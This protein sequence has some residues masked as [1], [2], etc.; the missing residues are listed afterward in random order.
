M[1]NNDVRGRQRLRRVPPG[2]ESEVWAVSGSQEARRLSPRPAAPLRPASKYTIS[3]S[4]LARRP[5]FCSQPLT[6][7]QSGREGRRRGRFVKPHL[8]P[9]APV[10]DSSARQ[11]RGRVS[12]VR[13]KA[14]NAH[15]ERNEAA[16]WWSRYHGDLD[17]LWGS[18]SRP[19]GSLKVVCRKSF[20]LARRRS[21]SSLRLP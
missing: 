9:R 16:Y 8:S 3:G 2:P 13:A 14:K 18:S 15:A 6:S 20:A 10:S 12:R 11:S 4:V 17:L 7:R 5:P 21:D 19:L 1:R